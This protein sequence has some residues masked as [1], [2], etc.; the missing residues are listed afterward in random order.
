MY[1]VSTVSASL[2]YYAL[3]I[4]AS[5]SQSSISLFKEF[6]YQ[7]YRIVHFFIVFACI[8]AFF[9]FS[10]F[11]M[12]CAGSCITGAFSDDLVH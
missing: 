10:T 3:Y 8:H 12:C 5:A 9:A 11:V 1:I 4:I 7:C 2:R 6:M